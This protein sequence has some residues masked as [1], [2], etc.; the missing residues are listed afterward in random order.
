MGCRDRLRTERG[1]GARPGSHRR[2][3][4]LRG[5]LIA[6]GALAAALLAHPAPAEDAVTWIQSYDEAIS[7]ARRTGRPIFLE[8]RC[9]P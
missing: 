3:R 6:C 2:L 8:F 7:E 9:A 1:E 4:P 5:L